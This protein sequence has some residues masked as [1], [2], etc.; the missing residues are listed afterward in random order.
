[1]TALERLADDA[2]ETRAARGLFLDLSARFQDAVRELEQV[3]ELGG[4]RTARALVRSLFA[5]LRLEA[6]RA[7]LSRLPE[8]E[9]EEWR[10]LIDGPFRAAYPLAAESCAATT[11]GGH[12]RVITDLGLEPGH[13]ARLEN[14]LVGLPEAER[15]KLLDKARKAHKGLTELC[16]VMEKAYKAYGKLLSSE[17][18]PQVRPTVYV[19]DTQADFDR[20][21]SGLAGDLEN[22]LGFYLPSHRVLVF[23]NQPE[24]R[25]P[26][27]ALSQGTLNVLLHETFH[28][29]LH[30]H[31]E[32]RPRWFDEGM[33]EYFGIAEIGAAGL[34]YG[35][36]PQLHPSRLD[37][38]REALTGV[39][40][41]PM[42]LADM[43]RAPRST[44]YGANR[45]VNYAQAWSFVHYLGSS[46]KGQKLLRG[47]FQAL[48]RGLDQE[49]AFREVFADVDLRALERDWREYVGK[50]R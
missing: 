43:I 7:A 17:E 29:W 31:V 22:V 12:Y 32:D 25:Q 47:Y 3:G 41:A 50:L 14:K 16:D 20:F 30:L 23:Y 10:K 2:P 40:P 6:A 35:L 26:G 19:L 39:L 48:R 18:E 38:I 42:S 4:R 27:R 33:A 1:V 28:Q 15:Q 21:S 5:T 37:N 11:P 8:D 46:T 45:S 13:L 34:R 49:G 36:V 9:A 44:F 24:G